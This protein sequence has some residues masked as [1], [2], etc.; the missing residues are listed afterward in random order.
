MNAFVWFVEVEKAFQQLKDV[1]SQPPVLAML[2]FNHSFTVE[3]DAL[4]S[5]L[6]AILM[7][8]HRPIGFHSQLL[9]ARPYNCP[10]MRKNC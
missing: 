1:V 9:K 2:D 6:G 8:N 4:R 7:Q 5:G 10:L 3:C